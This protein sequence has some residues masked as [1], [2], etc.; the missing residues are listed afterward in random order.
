M[1]KEIFKINNTF[2]PTLLLNPKFGDNTK[3]IS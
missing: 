2:K 3:K 1:N